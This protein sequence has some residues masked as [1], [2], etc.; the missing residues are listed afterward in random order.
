MDTLITRLLRIHGRV[1][2]V[3]YRDAMRQEASR[4]ALEGWVRNRA[5]GT[6]EALVHGTLANVDRI[7]EWAHTGPRFARV[8]R[9]DVSAA[10]PPDTTGFRIRFD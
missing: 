6:V 10:E 5:D 3:G 7:I 8:E 4:I 9:V 2:G 1:Q